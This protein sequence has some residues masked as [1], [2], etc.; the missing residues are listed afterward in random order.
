M[1]SSRAVTHKHVCGR[2]RDLIQ[3]LER[4]EKKKKKR[5]SGSVYYVKQLGLRSLCKVTAK[6]KCGE[7]TCK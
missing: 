6:E 1:V 3:F 4:E 2:T 5:L 7:L